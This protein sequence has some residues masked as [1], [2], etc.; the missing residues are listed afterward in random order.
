MKHTFIFYTASI[1]INK[2]YYNNKQHGIR[3]DAREWQ[4]EILKVLARD[5]EKAKMLE[6][7][8]AYVAGSSIHLHIV[9][10]VPR[11]EYYTKSGAISAHTVD[12]SNCEKNLIDIIMLKK[13]EGK[14]GATTLGIDDRFV[15][16]M[17]SE[18]MAHDENYYETI[19]EITI[20]K[21]E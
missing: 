19:V 4:C 13:N 8:N 15:T 10:K 16:K 17:I 11:A 5:S 9:S 18:K 6:L 2:F 1:S 21:E 12:I 20:H 3:T 7:R 14:C